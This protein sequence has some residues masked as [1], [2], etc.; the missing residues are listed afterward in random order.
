MQ[1]F[2]VSVL[3]I[4]PLVP[5]NISN[6]AYR[7]SL[8]GTACSSLYS[9]YTL[10]GVVLL[11]THSFLI[12]MHFSL[13]SCI[14]RCSVPMV[15]GSAHFIKRKKERV[16]GS[17]IIFCIYQFCYSCQKPRAWNLQ[18]FQ[19]WFQSVFSAKDFIY[20]LYCL[21]FVTSQLHIKC[22]HCGLLL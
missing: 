5:R 20:F 19:V 2:I 7:L 8:L 14:L 13:R 21:M 17:A 16:L 12:S 22:E 9:L 3:A 6:R 4:I 15:L 11:L 1:V 18:A 10:Y